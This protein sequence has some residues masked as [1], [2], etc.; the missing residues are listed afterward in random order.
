MVLSFVIQWEI[1][2]VFLTFIFLSRSRGGSIGGWGGECQR[3][4]NLSEVN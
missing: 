1:A 2:V 3:T 4:P